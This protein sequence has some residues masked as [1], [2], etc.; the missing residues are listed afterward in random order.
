MFCFSYLFKKHVKNVVLF[1][2]H[3]FSFQDDEITVENCKEWFPLVKL[4]MNMKGVQN[5]QEIYKE[6]D[7]FCMSAVK[8]S[9][10]EFKSNP[11]NPNHVWNLQPVNNAFLQAVMHLVKYMKD[12]QRILFVLYF[13]TN[14]APEGADQV[15][16]AYECYKFAVENENKLR[17]SPRAIETIEKIKRKFKMYKIQHLLHLHNLHDDKLGQLIEHPCELIHALYQHESVLQPENKIDINQIA[18]EIAA[19]HQLDFHMIQIELLQKWLSF[20]VNDSCEGLDETFYH[21]LNITITNIETE[22]EISNESVER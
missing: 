15:E 18:Q 20:S 10:T 14:Q 9:I 2:F 8:N 4:H 5:L 3:F 12:L 17:D 19:L 16:A 7:Y 1:L 6:E 22:F 21:D 11:D 13:V